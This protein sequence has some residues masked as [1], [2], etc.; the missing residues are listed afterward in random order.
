[1]PRLAALILPL[2]ACASLQRA[3]NRPPL[4]H[5]GDVLFLLAPRNADAARVWFDVGGASAIRADGQVVPLEVPPASPPAE[6]TRRQRLIARGRLEPGAYR[7][8]KLVVSHPVASL[9]GDSFDLIAPQAPVEVEAPFSISARSA[10]VVSVRA[11]YGALVAGAAFAPSFAAMVPP[12]TVVPL[13]GYCTNADLQAI[14]VF[15][16][17]ASE[18][19]G[20]IPTGR[21]PWGIALDPVAS[22]AYVALSDEDA[23]AVVDLAN[24]IEVARIRLNAGDSPRELLL[25]GDRRTLL[26]ANAGSNTVSFVDVARMMETARAQTGEQ[27]VSLLADR[28]ST[29]IFVFNQRGSSIS[30][31][32]P[33]NKT[34]VGTVPLDSPPLRGQIDAAGSRIY[35]ASPLS[36][37]LSVLRLPDLSQT[38]RVYIG[39]GTTALKVDPATDFLYVAGAGGRT[40]V[41]DPFSLLPI[42]LIDLPAEASWLRIDA[43]ENRMLAL[44]SERGSIVSVNL[45]TKAL[46]AEFDV[47]PEARVLSLVGERE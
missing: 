2:A 23:I 21:A 40:A 6:G 35:V 25:T 20:L 22:R 12:R 30:I 34:V 7:G 47:G 45:T 26:A 33:G 42:D 3:P 46:V 28:K 19:T 27:P 36:P 18:V 32:D 15:D 24:P 13:T 37:Y 31:V 9:A 41:F 38:S 39:T 1:M 11:G 44:L 14:T 5:E 16:R 17:R 43:A 4:D 10:T 8:F 29:R